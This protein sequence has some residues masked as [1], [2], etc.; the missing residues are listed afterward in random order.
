MSDQPR[1]WDKELAEIDKLIARGPASVPAPRSASG[2][3]PAPAPRGPA[4]APASA[5]PASRAAAAGDFLG[6]WVRVLLGLTVAAAVTVWPYPSACGLNLALY[7]GAV[8]MVVV[9]GAWGAAA[10]WRRRRGFAHVL[11]LLVLLWGLAVAAREV[12]PRVGY[13]RD[14]KTWACP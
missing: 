5:P 3:G 10:S 11:S 6:T 4:A 7:L 1:D 2:P 14:A 12:L 8:G 9:A 13:A